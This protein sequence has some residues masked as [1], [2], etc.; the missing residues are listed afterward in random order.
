MDFYFFPEIGYPRL[1]KG[2][3]E[4]LCAFVGT[5]KNFSVYNFKLIIPFLFIQSLALRDIFPLAAGKANLV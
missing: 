3:K 1:D 5:L 2:E 4:G